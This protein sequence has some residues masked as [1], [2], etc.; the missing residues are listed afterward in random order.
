MYLPSNM[1]IFSSYLYASVWSKLVTTLAFN[2]ILTYSVVHL[3]FEAIVRRCSE[4]GRSDITLCSHVW[5]CLIRKCYSQS[6]ELDEKSTGLTAAEG[7]CKCMDRQKQA[8][9]ARAK[10][11]NQIWSQDC[12][13][14]LDPFS[15]TLVNSP[16][17]Y[18]NHHPHGRIVLLKVETFVRGQGSKLRV[19]VWL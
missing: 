18:R 17:C 3:I 9:F 4:L 8:Q 5:K 2:F 19:D 11:R 10:E 7:S 1:P 16:K 12:D 6:M 13:L 14:K 15:L